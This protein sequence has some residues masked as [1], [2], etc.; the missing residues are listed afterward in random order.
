MPSVSCQGEQIGVRVSVFNYMPSNIEAVI[1]LAGSNDYKFV[2]VEANGIVRC[3]YFI[4]PLLYIYIT[5]NVYF[6]PLL[7]CQ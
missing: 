6:H 2:H 5:Y 4:F 1:V 3:L 7:C